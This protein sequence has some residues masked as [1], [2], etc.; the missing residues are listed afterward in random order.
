MIVGLSGGADSVCMLHYLKSLG[1]ALFAVHI[2]HGLRGEEADLD[3]AFCEQLCRDLGVEIEVVKVDVKSIANARKIGLEAAG[4]EVRYEELRRVRKRLG[5]DKIAVAHTRNDEAETVLMQILRG[6]GRIR[7][8]DA[9]V[10][11]IVRPILSWSRADVEDYCAK[12]GLNY[13]NDST[14]FQTD[15]M[16]N[17]VRLELLPELENAYNPA[18]VDALVRL[19]RVSRGEDAFL[20]DIA[21]KEAG[22]HNYIDL[23]EFGHLDIA[24]KRRVVRLKLGEIYSSLEGIS[25]EHV[26]G[27]LGLASGTSGREITLPRGVFA[28]CNYDKIEF[29]T[30]ATKVEFNYLLEPECELFVEEV[31]LWFYFGKNPR[32]AAFTKLVDCGKIEEVR[33]R[34]RQNG[35][36]IYFTGVGT[37]K[38]KDYFIDKK[39]P[40]N[41]REKAVFVAS[42]QDV[43]VIA[44][45]ACSDLFTPT[46]E[47]FL[48]LQMW[49]GDCAN[50][51][52][53]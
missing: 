36:R 33:V 4:R 10:G 37:K 15:F 25:F 45:G 40:R 32:K 35:D 52:Q 22:E 26:E 6:A 11:D 13:R 41:E 7:G 5:F 46:S 3:A 19:A 31:G 30:K 12:H 47:D 42:G 2:H 43:I 24:I 21:K 51:I 1:F 20:E 48:Y 16:R 14:N 34:T 39:V 49:K 9:K 17:K 18:I 28:I 23:K 53:C 38:I 27:V 8:I 44:G 50:G 29:L